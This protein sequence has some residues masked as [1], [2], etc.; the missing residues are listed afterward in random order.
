MVEGYFVLWTSER[1]VF[2]R[3]CRR[4]DGRDKLPGCQA[5]LRA[6][7]VVGLQGADQIL[8]RRYVRQFGRKQQV[9]LWDSQLAALRG[10][11]RINSGAQKPN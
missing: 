9:K 11:F 7:R 6:G 8:Q 10:R 3:L 5:D 2:D 4:I 1:S